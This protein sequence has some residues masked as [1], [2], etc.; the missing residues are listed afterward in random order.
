MAERTTTKST[1]AA[2]AAPKPSDLALTLDVERS[3]EVQAL[4]GEES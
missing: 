4:H 2:A 3:Q 1:E